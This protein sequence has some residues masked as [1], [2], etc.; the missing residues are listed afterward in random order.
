MYAIPDIDCGAL[1][2][3]H[4]IAD[5]STGTSLHNNGSVSCAANY[6]YLTGDVSY[7][8]MCVLNANQSGVYWNVSHI[9]EC[10]CKYVY[11]CYTI[12]SSMF[13]YRRPRIKTS[14]LNQD[15]IR[16]VPGET[17]TVSNLTMS[18]I[19]LYV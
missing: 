14:H 19:R 18:V 15:K 13:T 16:H 12:L 2:L 4:S 17:N 11:R 9:P 5:T 10:I 7:L 8:V 1:I 3:T 6:G